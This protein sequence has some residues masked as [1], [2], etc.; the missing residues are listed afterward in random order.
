MSLPGVKVCL[1]A[2]GTYSQCGCAFAHPYTGPTCQG[3][4]VEC[5]ALVGQPTQYAGKHCC[6]TAG[7]CGLTNPDAFG[8]LC[9]ERGAQPAGQPTTAC[10]ETLI[11]FIEVEDCCRPDGSCG[12][13]FRQG[14][15]WDDLG[16]V[17][18]VELASML[19]KSGLL[20]LFLFI[21]GKGDVLD[22]IKPARCA[23]KGP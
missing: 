14:D 1:E 5:P 3:G 8:D 2:V 20:G 23:Y 11:P 10:G 16:C 7:K 19:K 22:A 17:E 13:W 21:A 15:N 6:T 4:K 9:V 18:R 12:L